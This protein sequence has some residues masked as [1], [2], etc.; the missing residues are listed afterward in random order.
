MASVLA[1]Y[2]QWYF[3]SQK[4]GGHFGGTA[5][6][7]KFHKFIRPTDAVVD[8]GCG[9]GFLLSRLTCGPRI[10]VEV[11]PV[12][13]ENCRSMGVP[14]VSDLAE[15]QAGWADVVISNHALEHT[16]DPYHKLLQVHRAL[17]PGGLALFVVP[18]ER[19]DNAFIKDDVNQHLYT[20]S[21]MNLGNLFICAGFDVLECREIVHR[22][23]PKHDVI[24]QWFGWTAFHG[25]AQL[26]GVLSRRHSQV[27]VVARRP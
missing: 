11:N 1:H 22:W 27:M 20:W 14:V 18:C 2:D 4:A 6:L 8:F 16:V 23:P 21:P 9:G 10:G 19:H 17:K 12:A 24:V 5:D 13:Q 3:A 7:R 15:I 26:Y 25:L